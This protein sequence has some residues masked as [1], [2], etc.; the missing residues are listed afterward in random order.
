MSLQSLRLALVVV[1]GGLALAGHGL[2][3][4]WML[5]FVP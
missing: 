5:S 3:L 2:L 4:S 1:L